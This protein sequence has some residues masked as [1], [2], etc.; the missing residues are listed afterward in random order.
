MSLRVSYQSI[1][2]YHLSQISG[3]FAY[4]ESNIAV[5]AIYF[6]RL[7]SFVSRAFLKRHAI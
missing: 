4:H 5:E 2:R 7:L 1:R 6:Q 3:I